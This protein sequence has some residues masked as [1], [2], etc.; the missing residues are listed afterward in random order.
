MTPPFDL[1]PSAFCRCPYW[2]TQTRTP[3]A[4]PTESRLRT[5]ALSG[6]TIER[7]VT[8]SRQNASPSTNANTHGARDF[9]WRLKS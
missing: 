1:K 9:I 5:I 3:Y 2:K 6:I 7:K 8:M 4:A